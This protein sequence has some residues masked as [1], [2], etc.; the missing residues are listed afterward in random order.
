MK[1][2]AVDFRQPVT[3]QETLRQSAMTLT[4]QPVLNENVSPIKRKDY[5]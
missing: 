2:C 4:V 3:V 1:Q 5:L